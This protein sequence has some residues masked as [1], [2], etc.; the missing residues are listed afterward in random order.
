MWDIA[1]FL[2]SDL[3]CAL[4]SSC[5]QRRCPYH[6]A[7]ALI[8]HVGALSHVDALCLLRLWHA[9]PGCTSTPKHGCLSHPAVARTPQ[10]GPALAWTSPL[11]LGYPHWCIHSQEVLLTSSVPVTPNEHL[12]LCMG[13]YLTWPGLGL[14]MPPSSPCLVTDVPTHGHPRHPD[15]AVDAPR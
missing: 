1:E 5:S 4:W 12:L 11:H 14:L 8:L 15:Q 7:W 2:N 10:A 13:T 3:F 6:P 9:T